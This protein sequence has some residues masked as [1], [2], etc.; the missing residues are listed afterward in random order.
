M[1]VTQW[2]QTLEQNYVA[3]DREGLLISN[4]FLPSNFATFPSSIVFKAS[5]FVQKAIVEYLTLNSIDGCLD[6]NQVMFNP[7]ANFD[8]GK[9]CDEKLKF[10]GFVSTSKKCGFIT[11][12]GDCS[13]FI[14]E[15]TSNNYLTKTANC[16]VGYLAQTGVASNPWISLTQCVGDSS[17]QKGA[18]LF[19][20]IYSNLHD[21][22][23]TGDKSCPSGFTAQSLFDYGDN[24]ICQSSDLSTANIK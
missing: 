7:Q 5:T 17:V 19:G 3:I 9:S 2:S 8:S 20:G 24:F 22:P 16:P 13:Q 10:G 14:S 23:V 21:N 6:R 1:S 11:P 15:T 4:L 12:Q 18:V